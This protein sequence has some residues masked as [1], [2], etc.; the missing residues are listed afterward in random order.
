MMGLLTLVFLAAVIGIVKPYIGQLKRKHFGGIAAAAFVGMM[1]A[2]P[3]PTGKDVA[4][5]DRGDTAAVAAKDASPD[6][7]AVRSKWSYNAQKDEM[8]G[9][10][11]RYAELTSENEIDLDFPYGRQG[12]RLTVR[13]N[14]ENGLDVM[15][16]VESGQILCNSFGNSRVSVK[17]DNGPVQSMGCTDSSDGSNNVAFFTNQTRMLA[18]LKKAKRTVV[19]A[20]FF[21]MGRQQFVFETAGLEW[22]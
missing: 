17:F 22:K 16:S 1:I 3:Q 2:V 15:L 5:N 7:D 21:Q 14:P 12:G 11:S 19:E 18:G 6:G 8:R 9:T 20:E 4:E 13:Q 10:E